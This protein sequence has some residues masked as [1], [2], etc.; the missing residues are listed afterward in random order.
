MRL[1]SQEVSD[2]DNDALAV[3]RGAQAMIREAD[4]SWRELIPQA[5]TFQL[6]NLPLLS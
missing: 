2:D 5:F 1:L 4:A 3:L 6:D